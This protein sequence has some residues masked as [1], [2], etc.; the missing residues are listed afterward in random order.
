MDNDNRDN[1]MEQARQEAPQ[2][3][4]LSKGHRSK[5]FHPI[6]NEALGLYQVSTLSP[7]ALGA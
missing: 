6:N 1:W 3:R 4:G 7:L 2:P 5:A